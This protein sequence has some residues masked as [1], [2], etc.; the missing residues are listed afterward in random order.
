MIEVLDWFEC[1]EGKLML[2]RVK[3]PGYLPRYTIRMVTTD[4]E[5]ITLRDAE[6]RMHAWE[7]FRNVCAAFISP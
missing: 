5:L 4:G 7:Y 1:D 2:E 6:G 3:L